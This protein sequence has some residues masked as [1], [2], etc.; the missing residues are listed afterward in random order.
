[1]EA[2][3]IAS[4]VELAESRVALTKTQSSLAA[5]LEELFKT[6]SLL[7][8]VEAKIAQE[9]KK[10]SAFK[11]ELNA[12]DRAMKA[13]R[14]EMADGEI[15]VRSLE[16]EVERMKKEV[17]GAAEA[18]AKMKKNHDWIVDEHQLVSPSFLV[19][20]SIFLAQNGADRYFAELSAKLDHRTTSL[21]C[22]WETSRR[23]VR[24]SRRINKE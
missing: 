3:I 4:G 9:T 1:M 12:L 24:V 8:A 2:D 11:E 7:S 19:M 21:A 14:Q 22:R 15:A 23:S 6:Q 5:L 10:L 13:K 20:S 16:I 17:K 18:V